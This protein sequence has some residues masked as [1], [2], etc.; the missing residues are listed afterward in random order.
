MKPIKLFEEFH[1]EAM[2]I[3]EIGEGSKSFPWKQTGFTKVETWTSQLS[4]VDKTLSAAPWETFPSA[5]TYQFSSDKATYYAKIGGGWAK[6]VSINFG[7]KPGA[8]PPHRFNIILVISF[9]IEGRDDTPITNFGEQFRV[10]TTVTEIADKVVKD[11]SEYEWLK[12]TEIRIVPKIEDSEEGV[13]ITK[14]KRGRLYLEYIKKQGKRLPGDWTARIDDEYFTLL[15][16]KF[17]STNPDK[18]ISI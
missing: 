16:G 12:I 14:S 6:N 18:Y 2:M 5:L 7:R 4:Q 10:L 11:L 8:K 13:P 3:N 15:N 17:S 1:E 9:D